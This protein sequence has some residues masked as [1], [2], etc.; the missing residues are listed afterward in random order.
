MYGLA[1]DVTCTKRFPKE[2][3]FAIVRE[4]REMPRSS[5]RRRTICDHCAQDNPLSFPHIFN[6]PALAPLRITHKIP[7]PYTK[8]LTDNELRTTNILWYLLDA[9]ISSIAF[10]LPL[11]IRQ[12]NSPLGC[13]TLVR[14]RFKKK[15]LKGGLSTKNEIDGWESKSDPTANFF[16]NIYYRN[17]PRTFIYT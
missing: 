16:F 2:N 7:S 5:W 14:L 10:N 13:W 6:C 1:E 17:C 11:L 8:S 3:A 15:N 4:T 12:A 9:P